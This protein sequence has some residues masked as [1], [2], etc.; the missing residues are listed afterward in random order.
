[1][2]LLIDKK[3]N[4][5]ELKNAAGLSSNVIAKMGKGETISMESIIKICKA[6][7]CDVSDIMEVELDEQEES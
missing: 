4:L 5:T 6:L 3:M 1:M 7:K 2:K